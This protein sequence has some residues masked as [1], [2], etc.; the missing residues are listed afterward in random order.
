MKTTASLCKDSGRRALKLLI[1][2]TVSVNNCIVLKGGKICPQMISPPSTLWIRH[3]LVSAPGI[4]ST[5]ILGFGYVAKPRGAGYVPTAFPSP[6]PCCDDTPASS[7]TLLVSPKAYHKYDFIRETS[8]NPQAPRSKGLGVFA[9]PTEL[10]RSGFPVPGRQVWAS[11]E[12]S[13]HTTLLSGPRQAPTLSGQGAHRPLLRAKRESEIT[14]VPPH[15]SSSPRTE[16]WIW[17]L[18]LLAESHVC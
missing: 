8:N 5:G 16:G 1:C 4:T 9:D 10:Q 7:L 17:G 11:R 12:G 2:M 3:H 13:I 14:E 15:P 6:P 18:A